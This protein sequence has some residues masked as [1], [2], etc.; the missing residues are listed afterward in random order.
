MA[1]MP[2]RAKRLEKIELIDTLLEYAADIVTSMK[3]AKCKPNDAS[4]K[5]LLSLLL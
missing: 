4:E 2:D 3:Y 1:A 5:E